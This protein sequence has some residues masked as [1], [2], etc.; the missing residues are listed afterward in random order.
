M[1]RPRALAIHG[2]A[3]SFARDSLT[4]EREAAYAAALRAALV[5]G[6]D[7]LENGGSAVDAVEAAVRGLENEPLFNAGRGAVFSHDGINEL[8]AAIMDGASR[9]AGAVAALRHVRNP[10]SLAR[11]VMERSPHVLLVGAG[12]EEFA[13]ERGVELCPRSWFHTDARYGQLLRARAGDP[14]VA[15]QLDYYGTVGAVALDGLG[16]L[17]A[18]TSTGGMTN[19]RW[20]RIGDSPIIGAGTYAANCSCAVSATG[21]G[22]YLLR[23]TV[24]RDVAAR[25]EFLGESVTVAARA[26]IGDR[27]TGLGGEGGLVALDTTGEVAFAYNTR[28]MFRGVIDSRGRL[29]TALFAD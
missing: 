9:A 8:D 7:L 27:L 5:E 11:L 20:G 18:A 23:G 13:L 12:A 17:A 3:G 28:A 10:V 25:M 16:N 29:E 15:D 21:H 6:F 19:K 22:E 26:V 2:G 4:A 1:S 14:S 24:A